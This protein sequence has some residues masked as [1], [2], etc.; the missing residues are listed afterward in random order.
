M[1]QGARAPSEFVA[2]Q[3]LVTLGK[4]FVYVFSFN[5]SLIKKPFA[6]L[7]VTSGYCQLI[8]DKAEALVILSTFY[9]NEMGNILPL[10]A[11]TQ[12]AC[13]RH[14]RGTK[15]SIKIRLRNRFQK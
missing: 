4:F 6:V 11:S 15:R 1:A 7:F 13:L 14:P 2:N 3:L 9:K 8:N 5:S 12:E 10:L